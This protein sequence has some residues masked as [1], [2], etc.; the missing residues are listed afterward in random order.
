MLEQISAFTVFRFFN[1]IGLL[2]GFPLKTQR[3]AITPKFQI[4]YLAML[5]VVSVGVGAWP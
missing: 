2:V 4:V 5:A 3:V 1:G